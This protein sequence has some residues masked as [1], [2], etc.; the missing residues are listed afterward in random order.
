M[1]GPCLDAVPLSVFTRHL[2][3]ILDQLHAQ[4]RPTC[5]VRWAIGMDS[6]QPKIFHLSTLRTW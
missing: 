6:M 2:E 1:A 3:Q 5:I 4:I